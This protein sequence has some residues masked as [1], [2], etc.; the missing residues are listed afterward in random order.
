MSLFQGLVPATDEMYGAWGEKGNL[1]PD[2]D[3]GEIGFVIRGHEIHAP[4]GVTRL[5]DR[6]AHAQHET[7]FA[8]TTVVLHEVLM[9]EGVENFGLL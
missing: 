7:M 3:L 5:T 9:C 4:D 2:L 8:K 6:R 1:N